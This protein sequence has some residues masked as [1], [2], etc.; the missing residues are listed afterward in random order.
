[1][2]KITT[3]YD[4]AAS[5]DL[6]ITLDSLTSGSMRQSDRIS[7]AGAAKY[8]DI[9]FYCSVALTS[10]TDTDLFEFFIAAGHGDDA[11]MAAAVGVSDAAFSGVE[12]ELIPLDAVP[13]NGTTT[14]EYTTRSMLSALGFVP[15]DWVLVVKN[16]ASVSMAA[17]GG[18]IEYIGMYGNAV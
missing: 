10:G 4:T 14:V 9:S 11:K 3:D 2:S 12:A 5:V 6:N 18:I 16:N 17:S 13:F 15:Q 1:M 7:N 8:V